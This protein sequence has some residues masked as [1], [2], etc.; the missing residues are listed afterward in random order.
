MPTVLAGQDGY[1]V[2]ELLLDSG[3]RRNDERNER[4]EGAVVLKRRNLTLIKN[5][6]SDLDYYKKSGVR[7]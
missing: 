5:L 7:P 3:F 4:K 1:M 6:G 2:A